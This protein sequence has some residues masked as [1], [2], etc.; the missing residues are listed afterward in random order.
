MAGCEEEFNEV[1]SQDEGSSVPPAM[2]EVE[3]VHPVPAIAQTDPDIAP[4]I[5]PD[6]SPT[7]HF[8]G[9]DNFPIMSMTPPPSETPSPAS[10]YVDE[11]DYEGYMFEDVGDVDILGDDDAP[12]V[13]PPP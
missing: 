8:I 1:S 7:L 13:P 9:Y 2:T 11:S 5:A 12:S 3:T 4:D 10:S 6:G